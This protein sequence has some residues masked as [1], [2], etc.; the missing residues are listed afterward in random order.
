MCDGTVSI[1]LQQGSKT[2]GECSLLYVMMGWMR[3]STKGGSV[4]DKE[5]ERG[6]GQNSTR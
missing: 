6:D 5:T 2:R 3:E 4:Y 1:D